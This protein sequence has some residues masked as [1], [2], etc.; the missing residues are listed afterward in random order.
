MEQGELGQP[1]VLGSFN[2][3]VDQWEG[4]EW[5]FTCRWN[6]KLPYSFKVNI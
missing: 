6:F 1:G 5:G 4:K 3:D 2:H